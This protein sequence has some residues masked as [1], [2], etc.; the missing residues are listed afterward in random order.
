M[1]SGGIRGLA[2]AGALQVLEQKGILSEIENVAGSSAGS[3]AGLMVALDY[4]S[5]EI[6]SI[7]QILKI[8]EFND[9]KFLFG[10][11]RRIKNQYGMY[12]GEKLE[13]WLAQLIKNKTGNENTTF[14]ELHALHLNNKK[15]KD[16]YCTATNISGQKLEILSWKEWPQMKLRTAVHISSCIP[17]YFVPVSIDSTGNEVAENDSSLF[18]LLVDGGMLCNYPINIFDSCKDGGDPLIC[19]NVIYNQQTLGLKLERQEQIEE[20]SRNQTRVAPYKI[21]DMKDYS[22]AVMNLGME[23]LNRK[24]YTLENEKGRTIY[25][26]YGDLSGKPRKIS[27]EEKK[28]LFD[29]GVAATI[30][31]FSEKQTVIK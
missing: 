19:K 21:R 1:E 27:T 30:K 18:G 4:S 7:L 16:F 9:G 29:N 13:N 14:E 6:D 31:F 24:S 15:F 26:S 12:K 2:Y 23:S 20:F 22:S 11:I 17:F 5:I 10:K 8:Q 28:V 25:I 3:I